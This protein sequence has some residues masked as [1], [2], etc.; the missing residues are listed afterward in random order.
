VIA[1]PDKNVVVV[2]TTIV[3]VRPFITGSGTAPLARL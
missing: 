1:A 2:V 3:V